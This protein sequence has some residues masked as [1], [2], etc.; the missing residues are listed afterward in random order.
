M[1]TTQILKRRFARPLNFKP[2]DLQRLKPSGWRES[3]PRVPRQVRTG[4]AAHPPGAK[5]SKRLGDCRANSKG[6]GSAA[7]PLRVPTA[8]FGRTDTA[9]GTLRTQWGDPRT[10]WGDPPVP[11]AVPPP[12]HVD[13]GHTWP[14]TTQRCQPSCK[15]LKSPNC[16]RAGC[17]RRAGMAPGPHLSQMHKT[18]GLPKREPPRTASS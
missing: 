7:A 17:A 5:R 13:L 15:P 4:G 2:I 3:A 16:P 1:C 8:R 12:A 6:P 18:W 11:A 14:W 9:G 10:Q